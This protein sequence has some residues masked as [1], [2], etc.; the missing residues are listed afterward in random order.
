MVLDELLNCSCMPTPS[1][2]LLL[3]G[4]GQLAKELIRQEK[5]SDNPRR[6]TAT[7]R[8]PLRIFELVELG[9]EPLILPIPH[10]EIIEPLAAGADVVVSFPPDEHTDSV[11]S[12]ACAAARTITYI[13]STS[14]YGKKM[15]TIDDTTQADISNEACRPRLQAESIWREYGAVVLRAPGFYSPGNGLHK[16]LREGT[17]KLP[18][19][20]KNTSSRI[21]LT[22]LARI[23]LHIIEKEQ[24]EDV[25]YLVGDKYPCTQLEIVTWLCEQMNLPLPE[26]VPM[27]EVNPTLRGN[28]AIEAGRILEELNMELSYP[29]Y[30]DG[31]LQCL[32]AAQITLE[33]ADFTQ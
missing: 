10:A 13:S 11:L 19:G 15:G 22:D 23:V 12:P 3:L 14:V 6:I 30:K 33:D 5:E 1:S 21:H 28:R 8:N 25:T 18:D 9:A 7:T 24:L 16:R 20:G 26:S 32:S 17:Y 2:H 31:Y 29:N 27:E 4:C